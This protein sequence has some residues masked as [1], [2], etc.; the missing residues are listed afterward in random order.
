[1]PKKEEVERK[2]EELPKKPKKEEWEVVLGP[3]GVKSFSGFKDES[4][5]LKEIGYFFLS[6][7]DRIMRLIT[8][9]IFAIM[10]KNKKRGPGNVKPN[11]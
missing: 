3:K 8:E 1:M 2:V 6:F 7:E 4:H 9:Q 11:N 5:V 10:K